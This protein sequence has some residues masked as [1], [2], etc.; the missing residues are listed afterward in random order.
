MNDFFKADPV[1][2]FRIP[3]FSE[4]TLYRRIKYTE[5]KDNPKAVRARIGKI[6]GWF[7][8]A[9]EEFDFGDEE[10]VIDLTK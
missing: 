8:E 10:D 1:K 3:A 7:V 5:A 6:I 9:D 2:L 4:K